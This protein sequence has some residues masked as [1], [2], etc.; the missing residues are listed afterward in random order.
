MMHAA[1]PFARLRQ[2]GLDRDMQLGRRTAL[3]DL[4]DMDLAAGMGRVAID[5]MR[6][7]PSSWVSTTSVRSS[8][9]TEMVTGPRPRI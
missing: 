2:I 3:P 7:R 1:R 9:G 4:E 6:S 5:A 8:F